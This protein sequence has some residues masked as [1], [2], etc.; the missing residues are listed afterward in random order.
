MQKRVRNEVYGH[1]LDYGT[2][3]G[4]DIASKTHSFWLLYQVCLFLGH[5]SDKSVLEEK[6]V[7]GTGKMIL[8]YC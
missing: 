4:L 5:G 1:F 7:L 3:E 8:G 2:S 6:K